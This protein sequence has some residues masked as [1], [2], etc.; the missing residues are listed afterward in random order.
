MSKEHLHLFG[1]AAIMCRRWWSRW[2]GTTSILWIVRWRFCGFLC[3]GFMTIFNSAHHLSITF[4]LWHDR[5]YHFSFECFGRWTTDATIWRAKWNGF[6]WSWLRK[7]SG[8]RNISWIITLNGRI[9]VLDGLFEWFLFFA[10]VTDKRI[11]TDR[12]IFYESNILTRV[13]DVA[14][15]KLYWIRR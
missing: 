14:Y 8:R 11:F 10:T 7:V 1:I 9:R 13:F 12:C 2:H 3:N 6:W 5:F 15:N 4:A